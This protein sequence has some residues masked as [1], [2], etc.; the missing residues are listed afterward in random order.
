MKKYLVLL[1][2]LGLATA[3][4]ANLVIQSG[5]A[6]VTE[7]TLAPSESI[8]IG[9]FTTTGSISDYTLD[10]KLVDPKTGALT[11][12]GEMITGNVAFPAAMMFTGAWVGTPTANNGRITGSNFGIPLSAPQSIMTGLVIHCL[13]LDEVELQVISAGGTTIDA[14]SIPAGQVIGRLLIHQIP[15]PMT[16]MLLGL[17][18]LFLVRRK[19]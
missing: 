9:L 15:E 1:L 4:Q 14:A 8:T 17:G 7:V 11:G 5:G 10:L 3:S 16:L 12:F 18:S 13:G 19:K 2:I 6:T